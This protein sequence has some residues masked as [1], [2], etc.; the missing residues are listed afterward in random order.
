MKPRA[1]LVEAAG[2]VSSD[3]MGGPVGG[4]GSGRAKLWKAAPQS[5]GARCP[6]AAA[7]EQYPAYCFAGFSDK[8]SS[9][10]G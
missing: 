2:A 7:P 1:G 6:G 8:V 4:L 3:G 5:A 9:A 10:G